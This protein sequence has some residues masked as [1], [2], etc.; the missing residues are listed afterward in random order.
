[1]NWLLFFWLRFWAQTTECWNWLRFSL[2]QA[3]YGVWGWL[4]FSLLRVFD[5]WRWAVDF[6]SLL[7]GLPALVAGVGAMTVLGLAAFTS[8]REVETLYLER[9]HSSEMCYER[10]S[11]LKGDSA[12]VIYEWALVARDAGQTDRCRHLMN[13]LAPA[14]RVGY[15]KAHYWLAMDF[16]SATKPTTEGQ[17]LAESHFLRALDAG[18][19]NKELV[20]LALG[21]I[22][23]AKRQ[24]EEARSHLLMA[25]DA[26]PEA[27]LL[28]MVLYARQRDFAGAKREGK[29]AAS[30]FGTK[31]KADLFNHYARVRWAEATAF[32][33]EFPQAL[34]I[35]QDGLTGTGNVIYR[36]RMAQVYANWFDYL[37]L[38]DDTITGER[39]ALLEAGLRH[40]PKNVALLD[41]ML[42]MIGLRRQQRPHPI[43]GAVTL[44]LAGTMNPYVVLNTWIAN[45]NTEAEAARA[46][47]RRMLVQ[48]EAMSQ[49]HFSLGVDAWDRGLT[50][51][52]R[53]HWELAHLAGPDVP[54]IANNLA[55]L[56]YQTSPNELNKALDLAT[57]AVEK[58]PNHMGHR[59]TRG[60]ILVKMGKSKEAVADL[61][62]ALTASNHKLELHR[63]LAEVYDR[64]KLPDLAVE[65]QRLAVE[66]AAKKNAKQP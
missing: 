16:L 32:I 19:E 39:L 8:A 28:L 3:F 9:A 54:A 52:A 58:S 27:R 14:E 41:R 12:Q 64:L 26:K 61:E 5:Y 35:L 2:A 1:M 29:L 11:Q 49:V 22:C 31:A 4:R 60:Y 57:L 23:M 15:G 7:Q 24:D 45:A 63:T 34:A 50:D 51:E 65:H 48:G 10:L 37:G 62:A 56:L 42:G 59:G 55:W 53:S 44:G 66:L 25:A 13:Q 17:Q 21:E 33:E 20:H 6:R 43:L 18:V 36:T 46:I 47:L 30:I 40:D 38:K